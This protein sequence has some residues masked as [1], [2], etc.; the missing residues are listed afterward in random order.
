M[1]NFRYFS[2]IFHT[3]PCSNIWHV[4]YYQKRNLKGHLILACIYWLKVVSEN[5]SR[6][7]GWARPFDYMH[8]LLYFLNIS[9]SY[10]EKSKY[11]SYNQP[12]VHLGVCYTKKNYYKKRKLNRTIPHVP[13]GW[14]I[15]EKIFTK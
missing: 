4:T 13:Q 1:T 3:F 14:H 5:K 15:F 9:S 6:K 10:N 2:A 8:I 12:G 11:F 7:I